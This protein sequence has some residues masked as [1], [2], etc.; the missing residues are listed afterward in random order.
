MCFPLYILGRSNQNMAIERLE[1]LQFARKIN[2]LTL[3]TLPT[4]SA[5][6]YVPT[7]L[8]LKIARP[9]RLQLVHVS[10][11]ITCYDQAMVRHHRRNQFALVCVLH[12]L[13]ITMKAFAVLLARFLSV[14]R[15]KKF[16]VKLPKCIFKD[17]LQPICCYNCNTCRQAQK[18]VSILH[19]TTFE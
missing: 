7:G 6:W 16:Q 4:I 12:C 11:R 2:T 1:W 5:T 8:L 15:N 18:N 13:Y 9:L 14:F 3:N 19:R 10:R 17:M